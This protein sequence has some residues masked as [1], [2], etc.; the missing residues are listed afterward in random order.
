Q[1]PQPAAE[2]L[3]R[4][5][6]RGAYLVAKILH[7]RA[8]RVAKPRPD[9]RLDQPRRRERGDEQRRELADEPVIVRL[10]LPN[11]SY[12]QLD[13]VNP[14]GEGFADGLLERVYLLALQPLQVS[15]GLSA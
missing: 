1:V 9:Q 3:A 11:R 8:G 13:P 10:H 12:L 5:G 14:T 6:R 2:L 15:A 7:V 4:A